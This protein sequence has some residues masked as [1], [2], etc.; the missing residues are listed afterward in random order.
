VSRPTIS[1]L[2]REDVRSIYRYVASD[3]PAAARRLRAGFREK[4][5]LLADQPLLGEGRDD[6]APNLRML[7]LGNYIILYRPTD[8]SID[9]VRVLHAARDIAALWPRQ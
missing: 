6:L 7:T 4:F 9:V 3:N 2:A 5:R 8:R 1:P